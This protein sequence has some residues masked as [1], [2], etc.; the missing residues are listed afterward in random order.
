ML[1]STLLYIVFSEKKSREYFTIPQ[2]S[3]TNKDTSKINF[4]VKSNNVVIKP[5]IG[6]YITKE[7]QDD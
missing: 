4:F 1:V 6:K 5:I 3:K 2:C 7:Y